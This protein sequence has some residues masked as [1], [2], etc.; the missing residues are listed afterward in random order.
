MKG[1]F[2]I[3]ELEGNY[4]LLQ[5]LEMDERFRAM[6]ILK[7][8][9][10]EAS[11]GISIMSE[12]RPLINLSGDKVERIYLRGTAK[13]DD[14]L[15]IVKKVDNPKQEIEEIKKALRE[16]GKNWEGWKD[17]ERNEEDKDIFVVWD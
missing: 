1:K 9:K 12:A 4:I 11:N 10:F 3:K 17:N 13:E 2:L 5:V 15:P 14:Y 7:T 6:S 16:W 8:N